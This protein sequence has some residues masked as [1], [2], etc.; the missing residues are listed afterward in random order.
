MTTYV[1]EQAASEVAAS[2]GNADLGAYN[3]AWDVALNYF[4]QNPQDD[5]GRGLS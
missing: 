2:N 4:Q 1:K 5:T 3:P